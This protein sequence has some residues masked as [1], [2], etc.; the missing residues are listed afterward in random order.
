MGNA[1]TARGYLHQSSLDSPTKILVGISHLIFDLPKKFPMTKRISFS[2]KKVVDFLTWLCYRKTGGLSKSRSF[3]SRVSF[4][5]SCF[6]SKFLDPV[7]RNQRNLVLGL[8]RDRAFCTSYTHEGNKMNPIFHDRIKRRDQG[9]NR[10][11]F[12]PIFKTGKGRVY[13]YIQSI[14]RIQVN[15]RTPL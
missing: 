11:S 3:S 12:T 6:F 2:A 8:G 9:E 15:A 7:Q 10:G 5:L 1:L 4:M 14:T 13:W